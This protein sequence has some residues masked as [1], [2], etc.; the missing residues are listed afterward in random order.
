[1]AQL[2]NESKRM[3]FLA[4]II[5]ESQSNELDENLISNAISKFKDKITDLPVF[6]KLINN[7]VSK[8]SPEDIAK[9]KSKFNISEAEGGPSLE[10]IMAKA[11][12]INPDKDNS[13]KINEELEEDSFKYKVVDLVRN[14]TGL[15]LISL[16]GAPL[17][18]LITVLA[19]WSWV[20]LPVGIIISLIASLIV[21][22]IS[23]KLLGLS[24]DD[25]LVGR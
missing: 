3:Q 15:N 19:G 21:H 10:D 20:M 11:Q 17:G 9:F 12:S 6:Q 2:I 4:G 8:M 25:P 16:G 24:D 14:L 18:L 23:R 22:G 1:M 5:K 7:I 13:E